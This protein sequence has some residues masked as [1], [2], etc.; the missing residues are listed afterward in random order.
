MGTKTRSEPFDNGWFRFQFAVFVALFCGGALFLSLTEALM[1]ALVILCPIVA[2]DALLAGLR[3]NVI[4]KNI[5]SRVMFWLFI[6]F[7]GG[8]IIGVFNAAKSI[9]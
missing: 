4:W 5:L 1:L 9:S 7:T 2:L 3:P 8:F 6:A